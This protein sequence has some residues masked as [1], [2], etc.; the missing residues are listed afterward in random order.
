ML[1]ILVAGMALLLAGLVLTV[2][3]YRADQQEMR[4]RLETQAKITARDSAAAVA[5]DDHEAATRSL[6]ALSADSSIVTAEIHYASGGVLA[7]F[8]RDLT[9]VIDRNQFVHVQTEILLDGTI[10]SVHVWAN[11]D[12]LHEG[13][14]QR[15]LLLA[16]VIVGALG[17]ASLAALGMQRFISKPILAL[18]RAAESV[19]RVRL[20]LARA[21]PQQR[22]DRLIDR[23]VQRHARSDRSSRRRAA[24]CPGRIEQRVAA[25]THELATSNNRLADA[26]ASVPT[27]SAR[28]RAPRTKRRASSSPT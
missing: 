24:A 15:T 5:F 14:I 7:H 3:D 25:R 11:R 8:G 1:A 12:E 20:Q 26:T 16:V 2:A 13:I 18:S 27:E 19:T 6:S 23:R 10:G 22:R 28:S 9:A 21:R 17:F 4:R